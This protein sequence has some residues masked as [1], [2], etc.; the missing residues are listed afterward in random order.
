RNLYGD[1]IRA[2][3]RDRSRRQLHWPY[4]IG[5]IYYHRGTAEVADLD[6]IARLPRELQSI[7][8]SGV[9]MRI[10]DP[11]IVHQ[12]HVVVAILRGQGNGIA[13]GQQQARRNWDL[14][15]P[16]LLPG[17]NNVPK[18][19]SIKRYCHIVRVSSD[20]ALKRN[21]ELRHLG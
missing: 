8:I 4:R 10:R 11:D 1:L 13:P 17:E 18:V 2:V 14:E 20:D 7:R 5:D 15:V 6:L 3:L 12:A 19:R 9:Q 16:L 21:L